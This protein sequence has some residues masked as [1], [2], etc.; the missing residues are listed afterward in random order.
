M[1]SIIP[2]TVEEPGLDTNK[3]STLEAPFGGAVNMHTI[4]GQVAVITGAAG[5]IGQALALD[6]TR[7]GAAGIALVDSSDRVVQVAREVNTEAGR[8]VAIAYRGATTE[9][10][11]RPEI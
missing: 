8:Q 1:N 2:R 3:V 9:P 10:D 5:G 7:R 6:M 4:K 11:S